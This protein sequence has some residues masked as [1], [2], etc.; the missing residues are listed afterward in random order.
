MR[1][2]GIMDLYG[3]AYQTALTEVARILKLTAGVDLDYRDDWKALQ[4]TAS[5][6]NTRFNENGFLAHVGK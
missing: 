2:Y 3:E 4:N 6:L 5:C 1:D